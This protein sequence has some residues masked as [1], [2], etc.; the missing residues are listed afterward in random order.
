MN[1]TTIVL[2]YA[3]VLTVTAINVPLCS[4]GGVSLSFKDTNGV[5]DST[6]RATL[7]H[8]KK[9]LFVTWENVDD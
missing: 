3:I 4:N 8:D 6:T 1:K 2:L 7:C 5:L 9:S